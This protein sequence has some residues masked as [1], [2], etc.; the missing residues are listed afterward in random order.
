MLLHPLTSS[1][2]AGA[3]QLVLYCAVMAPMFWAPVLV[4]TP[5]HLARLMAVLLVCNGV[6]ALVGVL[7]VYDPARWMPQEMSRIVTESS[8][9]PRR[10]HLPWARRADR[11]A[12]GSVRHIPAPSLARACTR[13]CSAWSSRSARSRGGSGPLR[14]RSLACAGIAAIYLSQVRVSLVVLVAMI[15]AYVVVLMLQ[16]APCARR[17]SS[18]PRPPPSS[19]RRSPSRSFSAATALPSARSTLFAQDPVGAVLRLAR[20]TARLHVRRAA[21]RLPARRRTRPL[22]NDRRLF[23]TP[24]PHRRRS[25]RRFRSPA[26]RSTA[27]CRCSLFSFGALA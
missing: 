18:P 26:G 3:A 23:R 20:R 5:D 12:A 6:N 9:R 14:A 7:Q 10:G 16:N 15:A 17:A 4:R 22:G 1:P 8:L 27:V 19:S 13:R 11:P 2:L 24:T 25:G 21:A